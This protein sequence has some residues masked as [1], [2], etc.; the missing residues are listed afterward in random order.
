MIIKLYCKIGTGKTK[1]VEVDTSSPI[2]VLLEKLKIS[3]KK[4][5]FIFQGQTY[6]L[7]MS[8]TFEDI[9]LVNDN[10]KLFFNNQKISGGSWYN[11]EINIKFIKVSTNNCI[12]INNSDLFGLL[13]LCLLKEI[14]SKLDRNRLEKLPDIIR[15]IMEVLQH[16]YIAN[17][18]V[19]QNIKDILEKVRGSSI[20]NFSNYVDEIF[21]ANQIRAV[22]NL[23]SGEELKE[24]NDIK[25]RLAKYNNC[26]KLFDKEFEKT[27]RGS[28]FEFSIIS[29]VVIEREDFDTFEN[30]REKCPNRVERILY[31]GTSIEPISCIL[32]G[33]FRRSEYK[34][35]QHG[36]GV[37]FTD[38]L[39][40]CWYY[41]GAESNR[42]NKNIIPKVDDT[43]TLI[44]S[45]IYYN[46]DGFRK[47]ND[48]RYDPKKNEINFA[49]ADAEFDTLIEPDEKKFFGTEYVIWDLN[50]ICPFI[51]AK[52][53]RNEF[54]VIWR[55]NN[56]SSEPVYNNE[57]DEI[58][59]KFLKE[60]MK[61]INQNA[62]YNIYPCQTS[63]EALDLIKRKKY[64]KIILISNVGTDLGGKHFIN[65][66][67]KIIGNDVIALFLAY[68]KSHLDW[69]KN[70]PNAIFSNEPKFY[71]EYLEC[72]N[73][74]YNI[75][76]KIRDLISKLENHY[77]V[78]FNFND[79][80]LDF[81]YYKE[82]GKYSD[83]TF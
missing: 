5:K 24:I 42:A 39:D 38:V 34:C 40:Y 12:K 57:F 16:G 70:Y 71:E 2:Y 23:L 68:N 58:F 51:S 29:L 32:T 30:E 66:A 31:H 47:V 19:K 81:P 28:I 22:L 83:L 62:K 76:G 6:C 7:G 3:D 45:S 73:D 11:K 21:D 46:K 41:G 18:D 4:T 53:K 26:I 33:L 43:F 82:S 77:D 50:Q 27:K 72:F 14:S 44:A 63:Q 48:W 17:N 35:Y 1:I 54:C 15:Y 79:K 69:I 37:Y 10:C 78:K 75:N 60:R 65:E 59:K 25:Y 80:F 8:L 64:N 56:F 9:G 52:L 36:K 67:R 74:N 61:Y 49:Y 20:I 13:K 55:D